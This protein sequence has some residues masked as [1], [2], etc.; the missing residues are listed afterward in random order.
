MIEVL[1]D[2]EFIVRAEV[3]AVENGGKLAGG[4]RAGKAPDRSERQAT[5]TNHQGF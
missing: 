3:T 4:F 1:K 2:R 5:A